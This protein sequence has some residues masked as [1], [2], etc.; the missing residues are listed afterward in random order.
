MVM[1]YM[2]PELYMH[3]RCDAGK[4]GCRVRYPSSAGTETNTSG[5]FL[6][7]PGVS[8]HRDRT[9]HQCLPDISYSSGK[10]KKKGRD[11]KV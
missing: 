9:S 6:F 1:L 5:S 3:A 8:Q 4:S 10:D 2:V 11:A 7:P